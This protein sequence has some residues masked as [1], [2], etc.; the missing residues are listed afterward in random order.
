MKES[1][2]IKEY[3][4]KLLGIANK[5]RLLGSKLSNS[6]IVQKL[7]VTIPKR[8]DATISSLENT[9]DLSKVTLVEIVN[10]L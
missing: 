3:V 8:F 5:I 7:L 9:K 10:A 1:E 2:T 4:N 6:W